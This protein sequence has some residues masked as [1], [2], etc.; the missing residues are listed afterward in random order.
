MR[1]PAVISLE[2]TM[3]AA[4]ITKSAEICRKIAVGENFGKVKFS[5]EFFQVQIIAKPTP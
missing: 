5:C 3:D 2:C 1:I 4:Y